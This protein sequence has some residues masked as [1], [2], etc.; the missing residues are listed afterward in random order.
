[1][2]HNCNPTNQNTQIEVFKIFSKYL[3]LKTNLDTDLFLSAIEEVDI[4]DDLDKLCLSV[5][6]DIDGR[7]YNIIRMNCLTK[8]NYSDINLLRE[9]VM[10]MGENIRHIQH[11][12]YYMKEVSLT[13]LLGKLLTRIWW[14]YHL[15]SPLME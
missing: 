14:V 11:Y 15:S 2:Y 13:R 8:L 10:E 3:T 4:D 1:M 12:F 6:S 7:L 9:Q 5:P